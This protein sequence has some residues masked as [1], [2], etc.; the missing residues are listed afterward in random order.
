MRLDDKIILERV[1]VGQDKQLN[2]TET[3]QQIDLGKCIITPN[4]SAAKIKGNDGSGYVYSYLVIMRKP[5]DITLIP[6]ANEKVRITK[7]DGSIDMMCRV[8][9]FVTLRRWLKIWL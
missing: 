3:I 6:Q 5:K 9:G 4:S 7:K 8:S 2:P 1:V